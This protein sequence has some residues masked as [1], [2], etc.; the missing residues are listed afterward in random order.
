[1]SAEKIVK[2][3]SSPEHPISISSPL[4][5]CLLLF[6]NRGAD[7]QTQARAIALALHASLKESGNKLAIVQTAEDLANAHNSWIANRCRWIKA[8]LKTVEDFR[9]KH[10]GESLRESFDQELQAKFQDLLT[11]QK[12]GPST[13]TDLFPSFLLPSEGLL[14]HVVRRIGEVEI[15]KIPAGQSRIYRYKVGG[16][17]GQ[18]ANMP[19]FEDFLVSW[20]SLVR[21]K[22]SLSSRF[23]QMRMLGLEDCSEELSGQ[24]DSLALLR[25]NASSNRNGVTLHLE[26]F[27]AVGARCFSTYLNVTVPQGQQLGNAEARWMAISQSALSSVAFSVNPDRYRAPRWLIQPDQFEPDNE[28]V[29]EAMHALSHPSSEASCYVVSICDAEWPIVRQC[30]DKGR[31]CIDALDEAMKEWT[32]YERLEETGLEVLRPLDPAITIYGSARRSDLGVFAKEVADTGHV[33]L[34]SLVKLL[35]AHEDISIPR[36]GEVSAIA[37]SYPYWVVGA[38]LAERF[39]C[40]MSNDFLVLLGTIPSDAWENLMEGTKLSASTCFP[41]DVWAEF[42]NS[43]PLVYAPQGTPALLR[44]PAELFNVQEVAMPTVSIK[45]IRVPVYQYWNPDS[46]PSKVWNQMPTILPLL[47]WPRAK[48][49]SGQ[50]SPTFDLSE[51]QFDHLER[52]MV[53]QLGLADS[54]EVRIDLPRNES[55]RGIFSGHADVQTTPGKYLDLPASFRHQVWMAACKIAAEHALAR[56]NPLQSG[57][58][59]GVGQEIKP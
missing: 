19:G 20:K 40:D 37:N 25:L 23:Q 6:E 10:G 54:L 14:I 29:C 7:V 30:I 17:E 49:G 38:S 33:D 13:L 16:T 3:L 34:R 45:R 57:S 47:G 51:E 18:S 53:F 32:P 24:P 28:F 15:A 36:F 41:G 9:G 50:S 5:H 48:L 52:K 59:A 43:D 31:L 46:K 58:Q 44:H 56:V 1:M 4:G 12:G 11:L 55:L 39:Y 42:L 26:G 2:T 8:K 22:D 21:K 27:D 35:A